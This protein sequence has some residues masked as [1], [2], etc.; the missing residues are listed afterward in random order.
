MRKLILAGMLLPSCTAINQYQKAETL[1]EGNYEFAVEPTVWGAGGGNTNGFFTVAPN[2]TYRYGTSDRFDIGGRIGASGIEL[3]T[4][5]Q[6]SDGDTKISIAPSFGGF[7]AGG[8][9]ASVGFVQVGVP[10]LFGVPMGDSGELVLGPR[11]QTYLVF[12]SGGG[13]AASGTAILLGGTVGYSAQASDR[14]RVHPEF[15]FLFPVVASASA[16]GTSA[17]TASFGGGFIWNLGVGLAFGA[18]D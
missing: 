3:L 11:E 2:I 15:G 13:T 16:G 12:G 14:L 8:S 17:S 5:W 10:V 4:K 7:A 1:G 18:G 9:G 6:L